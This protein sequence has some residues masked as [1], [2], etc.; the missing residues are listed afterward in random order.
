MKA[1]PDGLVGRRQEFAAVAT[2]AAQLAAGRRAL[3]VTGDAGI[4][5][6]RMWEAGVEL[7]RGRGDRVL[8]ARPSGSEVRL[9]FSGLIDL[10]IGVLSDVLPVLRAPRRRALEAALLL[11]DVQGPPPDGLAI[12]LACGDALRALARSVS[13]VIAVDDLQWLDSPSADALAFA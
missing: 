12:G 7:V 13:V 11:A 6:T 2:F 8:V 10:F 1:E 4:G 3:L 9:A 5:K